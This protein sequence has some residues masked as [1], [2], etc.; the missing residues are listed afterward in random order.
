M[1]PV[2][3]TIAVGQMPAHLVMYTRVV[4]KPNFGKVCGLMAHVVR[5]SF[6]SPMMSFV[7]KNIDP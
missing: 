1:T 5:N 7:A 2:Y 4:K 3:L 6:L